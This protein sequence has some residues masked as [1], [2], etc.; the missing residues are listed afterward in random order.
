M[1]KQGKC[2]DIIPIYEFRPLPQD[3]KGIL[4][5]NNGEWTEDDGEYDIAFAAPSDCMAYYFQVPYRK[6]ILWSW[7]KK[8]N[9]GAFVGEHPRGNAWHRML[10][11]G[12]TEWGNGWDRH[13]HLNNKAGDKAMDYVCGQSR[14]SNGS[15]P[16]F[17]IN[18]PYIAAGLLR[19][20]DTKEAVVFP[21]TFKCMYCGDIDWRKE[22]GN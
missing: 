14:C 5:Y 7:V 4:R 22:E 1:G 19:V 13:R 10:R 17:H 21:D 20:K 8:G 15:G 2:E 9:W 3:S 18:D 16:E 6:G 12:E 11:D